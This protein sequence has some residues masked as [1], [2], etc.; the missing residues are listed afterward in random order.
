M[1][2]R[3]QCSYRRH[4][5]GVRRFLVER[6]IGPRGRKFGDSACGTGLMMLD[7]VGEFPETSFVGCDISEASAVL[8]NETLSQGAVTNACARV[9]DVTA[10]GVEGGFHYI[11]SWGTIH[12]L[13]DPAKG[14]AILCR[15]LR[16]GGILRAG[17]YGYDGNW[18]R[19]VQQ[20]IIRA[21]TETVGGD[22]AAR[23]EAVR[24]WARGDRNF[25]NYHTAPP[26]N[27]DDDNW[28]VGEFVQVWEQHLQ[29]RDVVSW[30]GEQGMR[31][32]RMT[33]YYDQEIPL[34][35]ASHSTSPVLAAMAEKLPFESQ[36][37]VTGMIVRPCW[38]SLVTEK[39]GA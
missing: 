3:R 25:K 9:Q 33:D 27:L 5:V 39:T 24:V 31:V 1:Y 8:V 21:V 4:A 6:G 34:D 17:V 26:G 22:G 20:E 37:Q 30:L 11:V 12:H 16:P 19:R 2:V 23:I 10:P 32:L 35:V 29:L 15:A 28:V 13:P 7:Y 18:E 14:I 38:L 36:C